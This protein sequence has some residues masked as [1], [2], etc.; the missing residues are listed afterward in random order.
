MIY[1]TAATMTPTRTLSLV[2]GTLLLSACGAEGTG[3]SEPTTVT[4]T[5]QRHLA[6]V[7]AIMKQNSMHRLRIDWKAFD[8]SVAAASRGAVSVQ[9]AYSAIRV[10]LRLLGDGHSSYRGG[11]G[12]FLYVPNRTCSATAISTRPAVPADVGYVRVASF[13][14]TTDQA[15][16]FAQALQDSIRVRDRDGLT[17]WIVDVRNNG[18]GNM[19]PMIAGVGPILGGGVAGY[20]IDP[21]GTQTPWEYRDGA[22]W[23]GSGMAQRVTVAY[24]LRAPDPKVAVLTDNWVASS[25]EAVVV[26]FRA[27]PRAPSFGTAT[28]GLSTANRSFTLADGALLNL[29]VSVMADR[30]KKAYGDRIEPDEMVAG[31]AQVVARAVAWIKGG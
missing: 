8:D 21:V 20:F 31:P 27:R 24:T 28:C 3:P 26:A 2:A 4:P 6:E 17:G 12:T 15:T 11:D 19:W 9:D 18:G 25:G 1:R 16:A 22:S 23:S 5:G 13:S 30:T 29:T 7:V 10:A 14:G